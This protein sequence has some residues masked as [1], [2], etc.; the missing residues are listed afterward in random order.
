MRLKSLS[1]AAI[2]VLSATAASAANNLNLAVYCNSIGHGA[3][4]SMEWVRVEVQL[5]TYPTIRACDE[6]RQMHMN[7]HYGA[8]DRWGNA[9][10]TQ[11]SQVD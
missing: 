1:I 2:L 5:G 10:R 11:C 9:A 6:A 3:S 7:N 8:R 4:P